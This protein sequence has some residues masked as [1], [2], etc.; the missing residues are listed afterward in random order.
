M[1]PAPAG[2]AP[3]ARRRVAFAEAVRQRRLPNGAELYVLENRFNPTLALSGSLFAGHLF[4]PA[5]R[6]MVAAVTAGELSKGT[7]RRSKLQIAEELESRAASLSFACDASDPVGLDIG[8][9][10]LSRDLDLL[11]DL[12]AEILREPVFPEEEL[13]KEKK[14]LAG[15]IRQQQDQTSARAYEAAMRRIYP[16]G[17]PFHRLP[18]EERIAI[19]ESLT[20]EELDRHY[21]ERY[22]A[23]TLKLTLVGDVDAEQVLER[24]EARFGTWR[25][26]PAGDIPAPPPPPAAPGEEVVRMPDKASADVV[27]ALPSTL[28]RT[29]PEY[30]ACVLANSALGQ[31]SLTSRLGVRVRDTEGLTYGIHSSFTA[32]HL[33]GPFVVGLTV[34]PDSRDAAVAATLDEVVRFRKDGVTDR[35]LAD[36]KSSRVGKFKVDLASNA[37]IANALDSAVYYGLGVEYLD[38]F[39]SLVEA[40]TREEANAAF[41]RRVDPASFTVVSAGSF[42]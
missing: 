12:L 17:H 18:G 22:G 8:G 21:S 6:R 14:R 13:E 34:R 30:V 35:E 25:A 11:L 41:A 4:A 31:S 36:E 10:A 15:A 23:A 7:A 40:V 20:R 16:K 2:T 24:L 9:A 29:D 1:T 33:P 27:L 42:P 26:G 19:V 37:G 39:P 5:G 38:R 28:T 32:T 3:A